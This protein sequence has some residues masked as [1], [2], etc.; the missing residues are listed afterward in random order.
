MLH[1]HPCHLDYDETYFESDSMWFEQEI[2]RNGITPVLTWSKADRDVELNTSVSSFG[3]FM[4]I[5]LRLKFI[6][7][8]FLG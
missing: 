7:P 8:I 6:F 4:E 3:K 2:Y 5:V 1:P